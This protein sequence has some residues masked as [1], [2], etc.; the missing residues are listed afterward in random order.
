MRKPLFILSILVAVLLCSCS[1]KQDYRVS[2]YCSGTSASVEVWEDGE[3]YEYALSSEN[4][5]TNDVF[6]IKEGKTI[7][8]RVRCLEGCDDYFTVSMGCSVW[9]GAEDGASKIYD[10]N[11]R[12]P[13]TSEID[14]AT[15]FIP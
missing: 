7:R 8:V 14:W 15:T 10:I 11:L 4:M 9:L 3:K 5:K 1:E 12:G 6:T 13:V 2:G